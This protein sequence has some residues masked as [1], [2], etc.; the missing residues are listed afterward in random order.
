[1]STARLDAAYRDE[2]RRILRDPIRLEV[3]YDTAFL[4]QDF[5]DQLDQILEVT[6]NI[7]AAPH[8]EVN[9]L[10]DREVVVM[11]ASGDAPESPMPDA[12]IVVGAA[13][14]IDETFCQHTVTAGA[15][16][17]IEDSLEH[18]LVKDSK[19]AQEVRSYLGVPLFSRGHAIGS[20]CVTDP[21]P[22][23]WNTGHITLLAQ[24]AALVQALIERGLREPS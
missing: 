18:P 7:L 21:M 20:M 11:S 17:L 19:W 13:F 24:C 5:Q 2:L 3:V 8:A 12:A 9:L 14:D 16:M 15:P 1:M 10:Y 23:K 4:I 22:K 6:R